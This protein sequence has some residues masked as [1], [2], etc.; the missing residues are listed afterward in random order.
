MSHKQSMF[1]SSNSYKMGKSPSKMLTKT[2]SDSVQSLFL[3]SVK[4]MM[5]EQCLL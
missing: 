3:T 4:K 1:F 2:E 5:L